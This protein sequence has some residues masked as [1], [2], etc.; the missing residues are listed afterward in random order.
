MKRDNYNCR[1]QFTG[2][3]GSCVVTWPWPSPP[4]A[5]LKQILDRTTAAATTAA[6]ATAPAT[7][8][9]GGRSAGRQ[10]DWSQVGLTIAACPAPS[11]M[12][13]IVSKRI[14]DEEPR[15]SRKNPERSWDEIRKYFMQ[16]KHLQI[17]WNSPAC[18]WPWWNVFLKKI[19]L[20]SHSCKQ[21]IFHLLPAARIAVASFTYLQV[22][23]G[24]ISFYKSFF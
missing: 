10:A 13:S 24:S 14:G 6:E 9:G 20:L 17:A 12:T 19:K 3:T 16:T 18:S 5:N 2:S 7:A 4:G 1:V 23:T 21:G 15:S 11:E 22:I 8:A